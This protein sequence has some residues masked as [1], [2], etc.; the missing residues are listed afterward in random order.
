MSDPQRRRFLIGLAVGGAATV[1]GPVA[2]WRWT[3]G[4]GHTLASAPD[5]QLLPPQARF[6]QPLRLPGGEGLM[7]Q[8]DLNHALDLSAQSI[9][10]G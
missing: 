7:A 9:A 1:A 4:H 3:G 2:M 6:V 5:L 10:Q 8:I